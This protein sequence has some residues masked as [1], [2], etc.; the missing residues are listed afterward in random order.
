[1]P[2]NILKRIL[3]T[4]TIEVARLK[5]RNIKQQYNDLA[6]QLPPTRRFFSVL[7]RPSEA[8]L[9][10]IAELKKA[11]PSR[12]VMVEDFD[13]FHLAETY[14]A[15][16]ASAF[17]VLTD[18]QFFHG[19]ADDLSNVKM[20]FPLPVLR[21]DFII[22]E[23]QVYESRLMGADA[24]LLIVAALSRL[25]LQE[26]MFLAHSLMLETLVEVHNEDELQIALESGAKLIGI[27]NRNLVDFSVDLQ[28][29]LRLKALIPAG[30]VTVS[31]SGIKSQ[32]DLRLIDEAGFD[33]VLIGEGLLEKEKLNYKWQ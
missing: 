10:L 30:I 5:A 24:I 4:K 32:D 23:S 19:K 13:P 14:R 20:T 15:L 27:N 25:R 18:E 8:P 6:A 26:L 17:S 9:R 11:S 7:H 29:S 2:E 3:D 33:A 31:E 1:M 16:G 21:K 22:D 12:G 28:T